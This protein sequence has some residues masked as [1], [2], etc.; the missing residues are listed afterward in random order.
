M[1]RRVSYTSE[2]QRYPMEHCSSHWRI[3]DR[4]EVPEWPGTEWPRMHYFETKNPRYAGMKGSD[5]VRT[6]LRPK[7]PKV[8][9]GLE[10]GQRNADD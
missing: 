4:V 6:P 7:D 2:V 10:K 1:K 3:K 8:R 9:D 5:M